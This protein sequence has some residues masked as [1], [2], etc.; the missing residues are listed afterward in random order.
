MFVC[1]VGSASLV[2]RNWIVSR[3]VLV[4]REAAM[5][6]GVQPEASGG[7]GSK[8]RVDERSLIWGSR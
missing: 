6:M 5:W 4:G 2:S 7:S 8:E 1:R 3:P